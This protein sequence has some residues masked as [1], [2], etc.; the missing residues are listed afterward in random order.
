MRVNPHQSQR[1]MGTDASAGDS[2]LQGF[3]SARTFRWKGRQHKLAVSVDC[4]VVVSCSVVE[5]SK[6]D[7]TSPTQCLSGTHSQPY[8]VALLPYAGAGRVGALHRAASRSRYGGF[9]PRRW[10]GEPIAFKAGK[11][12]CLNQCVDHLARQSSDLTPSIIQSLRHWARPFEDQP[13]DGV[14]QGAEQ[15]SQGSGNV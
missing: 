13:S 7:R 5:A 2:A 8:G 12:L 14:S 4:D 10:Q 11:S 6:P 9:T 1:N 3:A 15:I